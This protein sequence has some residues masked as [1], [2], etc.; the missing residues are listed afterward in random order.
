MKGKQAAILFSFVCIVI[1]VACVSRQQSESSQ[2]E[3]N[4]LDSLVADSIAAEADTLLLD[5]ETRDTPLPEAVDE[6]F[7]DFIFSFDQSNRLQRSRIVFPLPVVDGNGETRFIQR[8]DWQHRYLFLRQDFCTVLWNSRRQMVLAQDSA[9]HDA[10]V[11]QIYLHSR[12][13]ESYVFHRDSTTGQ[14]MLTE[15][16][17]IPFEHTDLAA[18]LDFYGKFATD[19]VFQRHHVADPLRFSTS[20]EDDF[21]TIQGTINRDQWFEFQPEMPQDV[22]IHIAYG[23]TFT[24]PHRMLLQFRGIR[25]GLQCIFVFNRDREHWRLT[26]FEN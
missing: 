10:R 21:N 19:S 13:I 12:Q 24:N 4:A 15:E 25:N 11:D 3:D 23:Q 2:Q 14:W 17:I 1:V 6:F 22:L 20:D 18:F 7:D 9:V 16:C 5:L 8:Q 26:E